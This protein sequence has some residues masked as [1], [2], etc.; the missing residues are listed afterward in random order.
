MRFRSRSSDGVIGTCRP[1][2][3][4]FIGQ[5]ARS[6][7]KPECISAAI[8]RA[9]ARSAGSRG[10]PRPSA[11]SETYSQ[12]ASDPDANCAVQ[13]DRHAPRRGNRGD[14]GVE[15]RRVELELA[16]G[17]PEAEMPEQEPRPQ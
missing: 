8:A 5:A 9:V 1:D 3:R 14:L 4:A 6:A 7:A 11:S 17:E 15:L 16:F 10:Q 12:I 13:Q 2:T